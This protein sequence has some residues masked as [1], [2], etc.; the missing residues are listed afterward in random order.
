M[1]TPA[2]AGMSRQTSAQL[3]STCTLEKR[4]WVA[5]VMEIVSIIGMYGRTGAHYP[6]LTAVHA[7]QWDT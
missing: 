7:D 4:W 6:H 3:L 5:G 2:R 1:H